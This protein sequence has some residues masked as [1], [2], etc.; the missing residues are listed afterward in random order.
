M[1]E[2]KF[3]LFKDCQPNILQVMELALENSSNIILELPKGLDPFQ[4]TL[5]IEHLTN[6]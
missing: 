6:N 2:D 5:L 3:D 1:K 4:L